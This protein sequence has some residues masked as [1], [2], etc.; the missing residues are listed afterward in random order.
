MLFVYCLCVSL[1]KWNKT[2]NFVIPVDKPLG[3]LRETMTYMLKLKKKIKTTKGH[4]MLLLVW[5]SSKIT[6]FGWNNKFNL[7]A[8]KFVFRAIPSY[9]IFYQFF[10]D[11]L[12]KLFTIWHSYYWLHN[13]SW[14]PRAAF[15]S[16]A[17]IRRRTPP[18]DDH[19]IR[20]NCW[21]L[22][23]TSSQK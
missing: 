15:K 2:G 14:R 20:T 13:P 19:T 9:W 3:S 18:P 11:Q 16:K 23:P 21:I 1:N 10:Q 6:F 5:N 12:H 7:H 17:A 8:V 4:C 22:T